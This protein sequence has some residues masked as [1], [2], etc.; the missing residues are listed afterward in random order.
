MFI[1]YLCGNIKSGAY[2][3]E[4]PAKVILGAL[5]YMLIEFFF[6]LIMATPAAYGILGIGKMRNQPSFMRER[7]MSRMSR[8]VLCWKTSG[9]KHFL[10]G[11]H[12]KLLYFLIFL[13]FRA[14]FVAYGNSQARG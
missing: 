3:G 2:T 6:P 9:K 14:T 1:I 5:A 4:R 11:G 12:E 10:G 8:R 7:T 13:L